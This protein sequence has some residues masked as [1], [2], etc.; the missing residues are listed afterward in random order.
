MTTTLA[1][2]PLFG[3]E[4]DPAVD[5]ERLTGK[6]AKVFRVMSDGQRRTTEECAA[7]CE[8]RFGEHFKES[9]VARYIRHF[10]TPGLT[11]W[12]VEHESIGNGTYRYWMVRS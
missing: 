9:S 8:R 12:R 7:E 2:L 1:D 11:G 10:R 4:Y 3:S 6:R 5:A